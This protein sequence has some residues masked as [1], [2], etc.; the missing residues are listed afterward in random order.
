M[1][2]LPQTLRLEVTTY[3]IHYIRL[4]AVSMYYEGKHTGVFLRPVIEATITHALKIRCLKD[5]EFA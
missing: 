3:I 2:Q 5:E 1:C 4:S